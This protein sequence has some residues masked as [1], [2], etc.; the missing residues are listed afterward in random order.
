VRVENSLNEASEWIIHQNLASYLSKR[1]VLYESV[2][3]FAESQ[4]LWNTLYGAEIVSD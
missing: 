3:H 4:G 1:L 2:L